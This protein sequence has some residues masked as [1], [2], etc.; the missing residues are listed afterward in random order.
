MTE[1][2]YFTCA[3]NWEILE[4]EGI[5]VGTMWKL[6]KIETV[7]YPKYHKYHPGEIKHYA[8]VTFFRHNCGRPKKE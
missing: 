1:N 4:G 2:E 7:R 3:I 6:D 5:E 8:K